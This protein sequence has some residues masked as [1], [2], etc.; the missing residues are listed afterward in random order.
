MDNPPAAA[1]PPQMASNIPGRRK[2]GVV[3]PTKKLVVKDFKVKPKLPTDFEDATWQKL[4]SAVR[5][6]HRKE[7]VSC[8]LEEL[9]KAVENLCIHKMAVNLCSRLQQECEQHISVEATRLIGQTSD[10]DAFLSLVDN[11]WQDHCEQMHMIRSIFLY[12][13][14]TYVIGTPLRGLWEMGLQQYRQYIA[15]Q[16]EV[17]RKTIRGML[18]LI[19]RERRG[20]TVNRA[21]LGS[22]QRML[23]ALGIYADMFQRPFLEATVAFYGD[24]GRRCMQEMEIPDYL[25]HVDSRLHEEQDR[26][27]HYL[28]SSTRKPLITAVEVQLLAMHVDAILEKGFDALMGENRVA[29]MGRMYKLFVRVN[30]LDKMKASLCSFIKRVGSVTV[31]DADKDATMV[32]ELLDFKAKLDVLQEQA[33]S[34]NEVFAYAIRE[35]FDSF[36]NM[37]QNKPAELVAKFIDAKLR[38][39][40][41]GSTDEALENL[42]DQLMVLF[43]FI[44]GKDVFE[45]FY[46]KDLAKRLLLGKSASFDAEKAMITRLKTECGAGFTSKLEGMFKDIDL[47]HDIMTSFKQHAR[48]QQKLGDIDMSVFVLTTGHWP[49]YKPVEIT[50]PKDLLEYQEIFKQFYLAKYS[51]RRLT[52]QNSLG[53]TVL[54]ANFKKGRKEL[55]VSLFQA[56]VLLLFNTTTTL[57]YQEIQTAT[58]LEEGELKRTLQSLAC[59]ATRVLTKNPKSA[60]VSNDDVFEFNAD[61]QN[62]LVRIKINA[63]QMKESATEQKDT[64]ERV[65]QDRQYQIDAAVVR[66][67][68]TRKQLQHP[69]L[70][71]ELFKQLRF[72]CKAADVKKRIESLIE[73]E[74]LERDRDDPQLY[75]YLA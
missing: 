18:Q 59:G 56:T 60:E 37:R 49:N 58:N 44:H 4:V 16:P 69:L 57:S 35:S 1:T 29:D 75:H 28:D 53:T 22:L 14:R 38:T 25:R 47:S 67:M 71:A 61:F 74:Y 24:E 7:P 26:V 33:F 65:F 6:V 43:R 31:M 17:E 5:A 8:S 40:S 55:S 9:Y 21:L 66:V 3:T 70:L 62:K 54:R 19:E 39:G 48:S 73:R 51:G 12:L 50:L 11:C 30:G 34:S 36:I 27:A 10:P 63:I 64:T 15:T 32:Q 46:K 68:K 2:V 72:P 42:M 45:A 20:E 23:T 13:D 41:K 52:F